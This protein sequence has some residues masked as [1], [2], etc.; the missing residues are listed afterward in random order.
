MTRILQ[1][2]HGGGYCRNAW[3]PYIRTM[4][5]HAIRNG[6]FTLPRVLEPKTFKHGEVLNVPGKPW[7]IHMPGHTPGEVAFYLSESKV[8]LSGDALVT[9]T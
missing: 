4:L 7:V 2:P 6:V 5:F 3:R 8:L 1:L 9:L